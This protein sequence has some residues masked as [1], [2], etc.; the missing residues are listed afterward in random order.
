MAK[1]A[2]KKKLVFFGPKNKPK[3]TSPK[4]KAVKQPR[5]KKDAY[6][7]GM[8]VGRTVAKTT[9]R[10]RNPIFAFSFILGVMDA[11]VTGVHATSRA[12]RNFLM[13]LSAVVFPT[14]RR[15][16][17]SVF[18]YPILTACIAL[19]VS[20]QS[21]AA[22]GVIVT[23]GTITGIPITVQCPYLTGLA[24]VSHLL[25]CYVDQI[26][27]D[28]DP[29]IDPIPTEIFIESGS[30]VNVLDMP[31]YPTMGVPK[32]K[33]TL[34][35]ASMMMAK[36]EAAFMRNLWLNL[37]ALAIAFRL[38]SMRMKAFALCVLVLAAGASLNSADASIADDISFIRST[39]CQIVHCDGITT[40]SPLSTTVSNFTSTSTEVTTTT[41]MTSSTT[42]SS[43]TISTTLPTTAS[44]TVPSTTTTTTT[45]T[46]A[47]TTTVPTTTTVWPTSTVAPRARY[48]IS[49]APWTVPS[50]STAAKIWYYQISPE[51]D[52]YT[53]TTPADARITGLPRLY[54][55]SFF[56]PDFQCTC[57]TGI[58]SC[59]YPN[60]FY[61]LGGDSVFYPE[62]A[63]FLPFRLIGHAKMCALSLTKSPMTTGQIYNAR[64]LSP[65]FSYDIIVRPV[66]FRDYVV[67]CGGSPGPAGKGVA[68]KM[69]TGLLCFTILSLA[70]PLNGT[71]ILTTSVDIWTIP[72]NTTQTEFIAG[73]TCDNRFSNL[74]PLLPSSDP[75]SF[76]GNTYNRVSHVEFAT[77]D[78]IVANAHP[79]T[80]PPFPTAPTGS[81][82]T[83][84]FK[85]VFPYFYSGADAQ[86]TTVSPGTTPPTDI[87][88]IGC[89]DAD[90]HDV[91]VGVDDNTWIDLTLKTGDCVTIKANGK[92]AFTVA[93]TNIDY[94][95]ALIY[96]RAY[97][98]WARVISGNHTS[99]CP[100]KD[101]A[102][103]IGEGNKNT[104]CWREQPYYDW[105]TGCF[106]I[107]R[108]TMCSCYYTECQEGSHLIQARLDPSKA[109]YNLVFDLHTGVSEDVIQ[110]LAIPGRQTSDL[111]VD[112]A[113]FGRLSVRVFQDISNQ[114]AS[115]NWI[116]SPSSQTGFVVPQG[117][118]DLTPLPW[119]AVYATN[120]S[121]LVTP[122]GEWQKMDRLVTRG[123]SKVLYVEPNILSSQL[124]TVEAALGTYTSFKKNNFNAPIGVSDKLAVRIKTAGLRLY[125]TVTK[126]C[127]DIGVQIIGTEN[128]TVDERTKIF[129]IGLKVTSAVP[130]PCKITTKVTNAAEVGASSLGTML[131][132][133][134][135]A[136]SM[137]DILTVQYYLPP[138][139]NYY[140][141][142]GQM[143]GDSWYVKLQVTSPGSWIM[144]Y[145]SN[146]FNQISH[147]V[148]NSA[149]SSPEGNLGSFVS[150]I[151]RF[152]GNFFRGMFGS[153][154]GTGSVLATYALGGL[155]IYIGV[156]TPMLNNG[157]SSSGKVVALIG[158]LMLFATWTEA[159]TKFGSEENH[160]TEFPICDYPIQFYNLSRSQTRLEN[161]CEEY[162]PKGL[163]S[164]A[165]MRSYESFCRHTV[166]SFSYDNFLNYPSTIEWVDEVCKSIETTVQVNNAE[167]QK[168]QTYVELE[169]SKLCPGKEAGT[170]VLWDAWKNNR[171][172]LSPH[173]L[174][175]PF[176]I[177][178][179]TLVNT[180]STMVDV[181]LETVGMISSFIG[182]SIGYILNTIYMIGL[183]I[184]NMIY[185]T[186]TEWDA[187]DYHE[188][189]KGN[190]ERHVNDIK[191]WLKKDSKTCAFFDSAPSLAG[192]DFHYFSEAWCKFSPAGCFAAFGDF[193]KQQ[194]DG[195][196]LTLDNT[197]PFPVTAD[198]HVIR[199]QD[200]V[201]SDAFR[202]VMDECDYLITDKTQAAHEAKTSR[203]K[204]IVLGMPRQSL[205]RSSVCDNND[206]CIQVVRESTHFKSMKAPSV[207][208]NLYSSDSKAL[209]SSSFLIIVAVFLVMFN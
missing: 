42:V 155:L 26:A 200:L 197:F 12:M 196:I 47:P 110:S 125:G 119:S 53:Q 7:R 80:Y 193:Q 207:W 172:V 27:K 145:V 33:T 68:F 19:T 45:T 169:Y 105:S 44:S 83:T 91:M 104:I 38:Y 114:W 115:S 139:N 30:S 73:Q 49:T 167:Y 109:L 113:E 25:P 4:S 159:A 184:Y 116:F 176:A 28:G 205:W 52:A 129:S 201:K 206:Q 122:T 121:F 141:Y 146:V 81:P 168:P 111:E 84:F 102:A 13:A 86:S 20:V 140:F 107:G 135:I 195:T 74:C 181:Y 154:F 34:Y 18:V 128:P 149:I 192:H 132:S 79:N 77:R 69:D 78:W 3:K 85:A 24:P 23:S 189:I 148:E 1:E 64:Q 98:Y 88:G 175:T 10:I 16:S 11:I 5:T 58:T 89:H 22:Q 208:E 71:T 15:R 180:G 35:D 191:A 158:C 179:K 29:N 178:G 143:M 133:D 186:W 130:T 17:T 32:T 75:L 6:Q 166:G 40:T 202:M 82:I 59:P 39:F 21:S 150:S 72:A 177:L 151:S 106:L 144:H 163:R 134:P 103:C 153:I 127:V 156:M 120:T 185:Y 188:P 99:K 55:T 43:T 112:F 76:K 123:A 142:A 171:R 54:E 57:A 63:S 87:F 36:Y 94:R 147:G 46:G 138:G 95:D 31:V 164:S 137:G 97:C 117:A 8:R 187:E 165:G 203:T 48:N 92:T 199:Y 70:N 173:C 61:G 124:G 152:F 198:F 65:S 66:Y 9:N 118:W 90:S 162:H 209:T 2:L 126:P 56:N 160:V 60:T 190:R 37:F 50:I 194:L 100:K 101:S 131:S 41:P 157:G 204:I 161:Y 62:E 170:M 174:A 51:W 183:E 67:P 96:D 136:K 182:K 14:G 93:L 108:G